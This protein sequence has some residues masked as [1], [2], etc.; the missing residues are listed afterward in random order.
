MGLRRA[1]NWL[2]DMP[3]V[4]SRIT[5]N[6][7]NCFDPV[8]AVDQ[9]RKAGIEPD[10]IGKANSYR[11]T[12]GAEH[13]RG[14]LLLSGAQLDTFDLDAT[15]H[16]LKFIVGDDTVEIKNLFIERCDA[17]IPSLSGSPKTLYLVKIVDPRY[18]GKFSVAMDPTGTKLGQY[19][20]RTVMYDEFPVDTAKP[21][22]YSLETTKSG[23]PNTLWTRL[24][25]IEDICGLLPTGLPA[26]ADIDVTAFAAATAA[27]ENYS[28]AG[29]NGWE[30]VCKLLADWGHTI[31][32][33]NAGTWSAVPL[34]SNH[35][36]TNDLLAKAKHR[37]ITLSHTRQGAA[38]RLPANV[39][40]GFPR[41]RGPR[42]IMAD[43]FPA[44]EFK[45]DPVWYSTAVATSS[46]ASGTTIS[47]TK[48]VLID[49]NSSE[50]EEDTTDPDNKAALDTRATEKATR[51]INSI[52]NAHFDDYRNRYAG[53]YEFE[54]NTI[55]AGV[56]WFDVGGGIQTEVVFHPHTVNMEAAAMGFFQ[57]RDAST[58]SWTMHDYP[59]PPDIGRPQL[60]WRYEDVVFVK[61]DEDIDPYDTAT[62]APGSGA[63]SVWEWVYSSGWTMT[64]ISRT[65]TAYN[66]TREKLDSAD[67]KLIMLIRDYQTKLWV[68][69]NTGSSALIRFETTGAKTFG[70]NVK[71]E[72]VLWNG[73]AYAKDGVSIGLVDFL[74]VFGKVDIARPAQGWAVRMGDRPLVTISPDSDLDAYEIVF[75][76]GP[77]R[78]IHFTLTENMGATTGGQSN[79]AT[80][81]D[82]YGN[83][84]NGI[85]PGST[86]HVYDPQGLY[87]GASWTTALTGAKGLAVYDEQADKYNVVRVQLIAQTVAFTLDEDMGAGTAD[88]ATAT[89]DSFYDGVDPADGSGD[90]EVYDTCSVFSRALSGACG[91]AAYNFS[92]GTYD[93]IECQVETDMY[94][95]IA[96]G[97][98]T[99]AA[100][101]F[102][103]DDLEAMGDETMQTRRVDATT[104]IGTTGTEHRF[105]IDIDDNAYM[106][107][108][109]NQKTNLWCI[110]QADCPS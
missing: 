37:A 11:T 88:Q 51:Y 110:I 22:G 66:F 13:G 20:M 82:D 48:A 89:V 45:G 53:V 109:Y 50:F 72:T 107:I 68:V 29:C 105:S 100:T 101:T 54:P 70:S 99:A 12:R 96:K 27:P 78:F 57:P 41:I 34:G 76:E 14:W 43:V 90:I 106:I 92:T 69:A 9:L 31:L 21:D 67:A 16:T 18:F 47:G 7:E 108:Q 5:F 33:N 81:N 71:G 8:Q 83:P 80:V 85:T 63:C 61:P 26:Y 65:V 86:V 74:G 24:E 55:V 49:T 104:S 4:T 94:L 17:I 84:G 52:F 102:T 23:S 3:T 64:E 40:V 42:Y 39:L 93:I 15:D 44:D 62:E 28:F 32:R 19:N 79:A 97:A 46:I 35:A 30:A 2:R 6:G 58:E 36:A 60:P 73:A 59:G 25:I 98:V 75:M 87:E 103:C 38:G 95:C 1:P 10:W 91:T 56:N 77:S